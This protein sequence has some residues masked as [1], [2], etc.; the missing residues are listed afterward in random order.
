MLL[1]EFAILTRRSGWSTRDAALRLLPGA[2]MMLA[3]RAALTGAVW[4]WI[5]L[6]LAASFPAHLADLMRKG[7]GRAK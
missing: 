6:A 5:A 2:L 3:L 4:W 1:L 7:P